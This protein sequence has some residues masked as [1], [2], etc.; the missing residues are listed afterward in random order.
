MALDRKDIR[1]E[2]LIAFKRI[3]RTIDLHSSRLAHHHGLTA[4]QLIVTGWNF[5]VGRDNSRSIGGKRQFQQRNHHRNTQPAFKARLDRA[6]TRWWGQALRSRETHR[7]GQRDACGCPIANAW[8][9]REGIW[10]T[11][12]LGTN[13]T[14]F[15][16]SKNHF[17][18]GGGR[19][20]YHADACRRG[21]H[22]G[23]PCQSSSR[24]CQNKSEIR[25]S[26]CP[27]LILRI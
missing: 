26:K 10:E 5:M 25:K 20:W 13:I 16:S 18:D 3:M 22:W 8:P 27:L 19:P 1:D 2:V 23:L 4:P 15:V 6:K 7:F 12:E 9:L 21:G 11:W 24:W 17:D 14:A